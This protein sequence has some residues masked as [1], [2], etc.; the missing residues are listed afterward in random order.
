MRKE[1][2]VY[3][4]HTYHLTNDGGKQRRVPCTEHIPVRIVAEAEGYAMVRR[5]GCAPF[6]V[7]SKH[8]ER[9]SH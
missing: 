6:V 3:H 5:N 4:K 2:A 7:S 9:S 1:Y 8:L